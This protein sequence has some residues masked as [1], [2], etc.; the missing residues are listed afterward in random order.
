MIVEQ[1]TYTLRP[2]TAPLYFATYEKMGLDI[3]RSILGNLAGYYV[4]EIGK[5]NVVVHL[6]AYENLAEREQRREK[7]AADAGWQAY[8]A[9]SRELGLVIAQESCILKA[10]PFFDKTLRAMLAA[11]NKA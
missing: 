11:G 3:Q 9:K 6:W 4:G 8:L 10:A 2:G 5:L 1:R 7:M